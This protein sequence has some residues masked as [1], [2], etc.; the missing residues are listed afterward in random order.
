VGVRSAYV[1]HTGGGTTK[2]GRKKS[3]GAGKS[4]GV[5]V[6]VHRARKL[7]QWAPPFSAS[8]CAVYDC[9]KKMDKKIIGNEGTAR[10]LDLAD[11][12]TSKKGIVDEMA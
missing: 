1:T 11:L 3:R 9:K 4:T 8:H 6:Y 5:R 12:L 2:K 7:Q 10:V